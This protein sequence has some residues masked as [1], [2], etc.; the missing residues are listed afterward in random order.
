LNHSRESYEKER[1]GSS[2]LKSLQLFSYG[3]RYLTILIALFLLYR[4]FSKFDTRRDNFKFFA[5]SLLIFCNAN[6]IYY[7]YYLMLL[8]RG[9]KHLVITGSLVVPILI[10]M[11]HGLI[12]LSEFD[13]KKVKK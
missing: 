9:F 12:N 8:K 3:I 6:A 10:I 2:T 5:S 13:F 11:I 1:L 7:V 4:R